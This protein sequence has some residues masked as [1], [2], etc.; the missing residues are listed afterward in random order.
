MSLVS[1]A[2]ILGLRNG[3]KE[4]SARMMDKKLVVRIGKVRRAIGKK[5]SDSWAREFDAPSGFLW[6]SLK[7]RQVW[8]LE[9]VHL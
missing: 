6:V 4:T 1:C 2:K 8:N 9:M 7:T 3:L 5:Y